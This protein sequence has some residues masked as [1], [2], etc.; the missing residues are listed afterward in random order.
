MKTIGRGHSA[1]AT[2]LKDET[3]NRQ[4][5]KDLAKSKANTAR[6][7]AMTPAQRDSHRQELAWKRRKSA[8]RRQKILDKEMLD[9]LGGDAELYKLAA[10]VAWV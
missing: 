3:L 1:E 8:I 7:A 2:A 5:L 4:R 9:S 10:C 6:L